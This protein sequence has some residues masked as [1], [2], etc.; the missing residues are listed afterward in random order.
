MGLTC[1]LKV[2]ME[3]G[4]LKPLNPRPLPKPLPPKHDSTQYCAFHQQYSHHTNRCFRLRHKIQDFIDNKVITPKAVNNPLP[5]R[6]R[7]LSRNINP[8][9]SLPT[10][11]YYPSQHIIPTNRPKPIVFIPESSN[12][13]LSKRHE[14]LEEM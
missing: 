12:S 13:N 8:T 9:H 11:N 7:L 1:A 14:I 3:K 5:D 6:N 2:L 4:Y 10:T